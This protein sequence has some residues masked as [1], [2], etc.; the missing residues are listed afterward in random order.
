MRGKI[1]KFGCDQI[2]AL[3]ESGRNSYQE[4]DRPFLLRVTL[5]A[6]IFLEARSLR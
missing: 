5:Q 4:T 3:Q 1:D 6:K 2:M